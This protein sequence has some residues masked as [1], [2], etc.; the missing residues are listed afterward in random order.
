MAGIAVDL[1][2]GWDLMNNEEKLAWLNKNDT[3][4]ISIPADFGERG[5]RIDPFGGYKDPKRAQS[6]V[7]GGYMK[8][9]GFRNQRSSY[10][11]RRPKGMYSAKQ[12]ELRKRFTDPAWREAN[13]YGKRE[14]L[15]QFLSTKPKAREMAYTTPKGVTKFRVSR[16][17][18]GLLGS[19]VGRKRF[20]KWLEDVIPTGAR[21]ITDL[22]AAKALAN[23]EHA[24]N[25]NRRPSFSVKR[26]NPF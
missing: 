24:K 13:L 4:N 25:A 18:K 12:L 15:N 11:A 19:K 16:A 1:P 17:A 6:A 23:Y 3:V 7:R 26:E 14:S 21:S 9:G 20:W 22:D 2:V 5:S 10:N 8:P